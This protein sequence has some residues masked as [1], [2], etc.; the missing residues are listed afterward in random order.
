[1]TSKEK[2][3]KS[4]CVQFLFLSVMGILVYNA[5]VYAEDAEDWMPDTTLRESVREALEIPMH[6]PLTLEKLQHLTKLNVL[7]SQISDLTGLEFAINLS[8]LNLSGNE[9]SDL[10]PLSSLSML[11]WLDLPKNKI[12]DVTP[13]FGLKR[14]EVLKLW[15]NQIIDITP[16]AGLTNLRVLELANNQIEDFS[17]LSELT[18]LE[19]L[20]VQRNVSVDISAIPTTNLIK[21]IYDKSCDLDRIPIEERIANRNYPSVFGAWHADIINRPTADRYESIAYHDLFFTGITLG[22]QWRSTSEGMKIFGDFNGAKRRRDAMLSQ[23]PNLVFLVTLDYSAAG[24]SAYPEDWPYWLRDKSGSLIHDERWG[25]TLIDFTHP[26]AQDIFV[27]QAIQVAKCGIFDGIFMDWWNE[28]DE[29]NDEL[30]HLY[31][32]SKVEA[33]ISLARRIRE[34]VG[35]NFLIIVNTNRRKVPRSAPYVNGTFMETIDGRDHA[36]FAE[37]ESTLLWAERNFQ[38]PQI[39]C[40]EGWADRKEP[41]DSPKNQRWMRVFTTLSLT[42]SNGYVNFVSGIVSPKHTHLYEIWEGHS[43]EH[44]RSERHDHTHQHIWHP[45]WDAPLGHPVGE[46]GTPYENQEGLFIREF[47]NGWA[48]YNRSGKEQQIEFSEAVS[49]IASGVEEKRSHVLPDLDGEIYLKSASGLETPPTVDV[50]GDGAVNIQD[51]VIVANALGEAAP[52][53]NGDGVVNIQDLV[54]CCQCVLKKEIIL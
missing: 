22:V 37:M 4:L 47:T 34:A 38:Y 48:V 14:L 13:L 15:H 27:Q 43:D 35:D 51:L 33:H 31:H 9:I 52:D 42:H 54:A 18:N 49:G 6:D 40:L 20:T 23:N 45:F 8:V 11:V 50:N 21:F 1:M 28:S 12:V 46:K 25:F 16:L 39:N 44:A 7:D 53:L 32:S 30:K 5:S 29:W 26:E 24:P 17:P 3:C 41:L 19:V 10:T 2:L 36:G